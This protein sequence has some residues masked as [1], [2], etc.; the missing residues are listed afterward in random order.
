MNFIAHEMA[1]QNLPEQSKLLQKVLDYFKM[2]INN[3]SS[4]Q[5]SERENSWLE[6]LETDRMSCHSL[7]SILSMAKTAK[8]YR[9]MQYIFE[10]EKT[11]ENVLSCFLSN[12]RRRDEMFTYIRS[13]VHDFERKIF[14]QFYEHFEQLLTIDASTTTNI[15]IDYY[16]N[17]MKQFIH[18]IEHNKRCYFNFIRLLLQHNICID[19]S[20]CEKYLDLLCQYQVEDVEKFLRENE[21]YRIECALEIMQKYKLFD[22]IIYLYEKKGDFE[23]AFNLSLD[24]L[25]KATESTA[26]QLALALSELCTRA[27]CQFGDSDREKLWFTFI[28]TVL[29]RQDLMS[30]TRNILHA[31]S[32]HIDLSNLVQLILSS[33]TKMGKF[34]DI[35]H[36]IIGMLTSSK[37][38]SSLLQTTSQIFGRDLNAKLVKEKQAAAKGFAI[39]WIKCNVCRLYLHNQ[40]KILI[41]GLC[42]H[43]VHVDCLPDNIK[44]D[45]LNVKECT[46]CNLTLCNQNPIKLANPNENIFYCETKYDSEKLLLQAPPRILNKH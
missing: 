21:N 40:Q 13:H 32:S 35:K 24:L 15:V 28:K 43:G 18:K 37:H 3:D 1:T 9:V 5:H 27:S 22:C 8:C 10:K 16:L 26:E 17:D 39:R 7:S 44:S 29:S 45:E 20:D 46:R 6:L 14:E 38:E 2:E 25:K 42:G 19:S 11:F 41:F 34:G 4:R 30:V 12:P 23:S 36:L 31:A 33:E